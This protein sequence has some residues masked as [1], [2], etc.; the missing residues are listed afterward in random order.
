[1][2]L[3]RVTGQQGREYLREQ[4]TAGRRLQVIAGAETPEQVGIGIVPALPAGRIAH[5]AVTRHSPLQQE[6]VSDDPCS[7]HILSSDPG[8]AEVGL[9]NA[10]GRVATIWMVV[11][12][13]PER[14]HDCQVTTRRRRAA[15]VRRLRTPPRH[16][17]APS[18]GRNRS[19]GACI[20]ISV[21]YLV[22]HH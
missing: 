22:Y 7:S 19:A 16:P 20:L 11:G 10:E 15:H 13:Q 14:V 21:R 3:Q 6:S 9:I 17:V 18:R 8:G 2:K 1:M 12:T 4:L 5:G